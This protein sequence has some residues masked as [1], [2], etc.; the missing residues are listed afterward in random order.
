M[1]GQVKTLTITP[2]APPLSTAQPERSNHGGGLLS[3]AGKAAGLIV[4]IVLLILA[5]VALFIRYWFH[6]R[7]TAGAIAV[8]SIAGDDTPQRRP[9]RLSQMGLISGNQRS[10]DD[11]M[12]P[13]LYTSGWGAGS[14][15]EKSPADTGTP[16]DHRASYP[17]IIDQRLEP[18]AL[19][20]PNNDNGSRV[21]VR[22]FR[23]DQDYS[24]R[25]LRVSPMSIT[26][27]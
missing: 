8:T 10:N 14:G 23:D 6:R 18:T 17:R 19:W 2:T 16:I 26:R 7:R 27:I 1:T 11:R 13:G 21:S 12:L 15:T 25:M 5:I 9:S 3:N 20:T 22:S 24:R 4:G